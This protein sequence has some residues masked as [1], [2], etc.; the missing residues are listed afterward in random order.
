[1]ENRINER[2]DPALSPRGK[3]DDLHLSADMEIPGRVRMNMRNLSLGGFCVQSADLGPEQLSF[4]K[5]HDTF[6]VRI[7][8]G[9]DFFLVGVR[10]VWESAAAGDSGMRYSAGLS[11]T[12]ISPEDNLTLSSLL[13]RMRRG[14]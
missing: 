11:I 6:F 7:N 3:G 8:S 2:F 12:V 9:R 14:G 13:E 4:L 5:S 1:M 10:K